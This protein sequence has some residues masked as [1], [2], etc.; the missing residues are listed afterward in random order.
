MSAAANL[1]FLSFLCKLVHRNFKFKAAL[2]LKVAR[3]PLIPK[4]ASKVAPIAGELRNR[5]SRGHLFV[6]VG[7][8]LAVC[9]GSA[10]NVNSLRTTSIGLNHGLFDEV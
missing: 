2:E 10:A 4:F 7:P 5:S 3:A 9:V 8:D 1:K 6:I